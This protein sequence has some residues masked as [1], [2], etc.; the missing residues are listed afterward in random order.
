MPNFSE[1]YIGQTRLLLT[2]LPYVG[3]QTDFALKG[4][5]AINFFYR[6]GPRLSVDIDLHYLPDQPRK[7]AV[8]RI[9]SNMEAIGAS[10]Q[11]MLPGSQYSLHP[12]T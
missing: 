10:L 2:V 9:R 6:D 8:A 1:R 12:Q 3:R 5:T 11:R 7:E 4:G